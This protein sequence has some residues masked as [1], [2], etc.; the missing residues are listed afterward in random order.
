MNKSKRLNGPNDSMVA[1]IPSPKDKSN[2][3]IQ[4][5][6]NYNMYLCEDAKRRGSIDLEECVYDTNLLD[7]ID[8]NT[9]V[10]NLCYFYLIYFKN[11]QKCLN[12]LK[13]LRSSSIMLRLI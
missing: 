13:F 5:V 11:I 6:Q 2:K 4:N 7:K 9:R 1:S 10:I 3:K 8:I 12:F